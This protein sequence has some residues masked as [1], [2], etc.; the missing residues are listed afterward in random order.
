MRMTTNGCGCLLV[1]VACIAIDVIAFFC[2]RA[3]IGMLL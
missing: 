3:I 2:I 1:I